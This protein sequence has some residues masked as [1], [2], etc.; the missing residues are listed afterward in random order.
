[1]KKSQYKLGIDVP[2]VTRDVAL[3]LMVH[4]IELAAAYYEATPEDKGAVRLE[5][6][7]LLKSSIP[8]FEDPAIV[9]ARAMLIALNA[10]YEA[11][12]GQD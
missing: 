6:E 12:K 7:R 5:A 10:H 3:K 4:H 2:R 8:G 9:A 11:M 1:M